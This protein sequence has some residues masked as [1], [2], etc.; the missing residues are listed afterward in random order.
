MGGHVSRMA[1]ALALALARMVPPAFCRGPRWPG[2]FPQNHLLALCLGAKG[3]Q[4]HPSFLLFLFP[5]GSV[6]HSFPMSTL[7]L[8]LPHPSVPTRVCLFF[9][10]LGA[11]PTRIDPLSSSVWEAIRALPCLLL[12][13][14]RVQNKSEITQKPV[15]KMCVCAHVGQEY[16]RSLWQ[17]EGTGHG[18][19]A[20]RTCSVT[21]NSANRE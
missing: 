21:G 11:T 18:A 16:H 14:G 7:S 4:P 3:S 9:Q 17:P 1:R 12:N 6:P 5:S 15:P 13:L 8:L 19:E 10:I 20:Q 2:C